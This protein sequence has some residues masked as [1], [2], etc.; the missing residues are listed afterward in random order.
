MP[1]LQKG[2]IDRSNQSLYSYASTRNTFEVLQKRTEETSGFSRK[3]G[4][5]FLFCFF[6]C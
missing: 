1:Y 5:E 4:V 6:L 3:T 2:H